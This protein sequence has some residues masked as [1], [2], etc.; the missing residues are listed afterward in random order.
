[1]KFSSKT[2]V[3]NKKKETATLLK[4]S[5][6]KHSIMRPFILVCITVFFNAVLQR[7]GSGS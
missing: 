4:K 3:A 1:M 7:F 2:F 5:P 6:K